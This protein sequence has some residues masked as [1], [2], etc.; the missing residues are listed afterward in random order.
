MILPH[1]TSLLFD[2]N[3]PLR[4]CPTDKSQTCDWSNYNSAE[5][6]PNVLTGALVGGPGPNDHFNDKRDDYIQ[7]EV[8]TDYNAG[9]QSVLAGGCLFTI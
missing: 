7:N 9:F 8:T 5:P 2:P 6:N 1:D 3:P 4:S